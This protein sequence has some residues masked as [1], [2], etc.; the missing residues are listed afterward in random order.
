MLFI[1]L[2]HSKLAAKLLFFCAPDKYLTRSNSTIFV[3][4]FLVMSI[5]PIEIW[6]AA[7]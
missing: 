4:Y 3:Y 5:K 2:N 1:I 7:N 6:I